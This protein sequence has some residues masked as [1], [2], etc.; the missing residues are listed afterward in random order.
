[1]WF[2]AKGICKVTEWVSNQARRHHES[3][4]GQGELIG[5]RNILKHRWKG[6]QLPLMWPK[7]RYETSTYCE[8]IEISE[9]VIGELIKLEPAIYRI[10]NNEVQAERLITELRHIHKQR[11]ITTESFWSTFSSS[12]KSLLNTEKLT[13]PEGRVGIVGCWTQITLVAPRKAL[14]KDLYIR[15]PA[16]LWVE[17]ADPRGAGMVFFDKVRYEDYAA[18]MHEASSCISFVHEGPSKKLLAF[19]VED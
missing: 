12:G 5:E 9:K 11:D 1:M 6:K 8:I 4:L 19:S 15:G 16:T 18:T 2:L 14:D 3:H 7:R 10:I 17:P 13:V